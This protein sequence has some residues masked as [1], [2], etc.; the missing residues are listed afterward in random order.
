LAKQQGKVFF[1]FIFTS[2][3]VTQE[4]CPIPALA[5]GVSYRINRDIYGADYMPDL[6]E[7]KPDNGSKT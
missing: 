3:P 4:M 5:C 6:P 2:F 1:T 7:Q